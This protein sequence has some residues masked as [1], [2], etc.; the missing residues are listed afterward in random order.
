MADRPDI[1]ALLI[2]ALYGELTP[3]DE[4]RLTAHLESH[5]ADRTAL[6]NLTRTR[7]AIRESRIL[8]TL[9]EPP[10]S[11]SALLL[12]EAA[13]RAP[14]SSPTESWFQ[15]F[16]R[17][18]AAHPA[19]AAAATLV[20]VVGV[21]GLLYMRNSDPFSAPQA[22]RAAV[23]MSATANE[24]KAA[25]SAPSAAGS[26]ALPPA[27]DNSIVAAPEGVSDGKAPPSNKAYR[28]DV[29][30]ELATPT[31][32]AP[33][34]LAKGGIEVHRD[35]P[36][37]KDFD[38][39]VVARSRAGLSKESP[40]SGGAGGTGAVLGQAPAATA[41][42]PQPAT[43]MQAAASPEEPSS[44]P[45]GASGDLISARN[46]GADKPVTAPAPAA[47][48]KP[49]PATVTSAS[50]AE[51]E[52]EAKPSKL[53]KKRAPR[54][55]AKS[56]LPPSDEQVVLGWAQRQRDQVIAYVRANNCR[57]AAAAATEVYNRA[58]DYYASNIA[59]DRSIKPCA[60]YL[61]NERESVDRKRAAAKRTN[62]DE[63]AASKI[64]SAA[65]PAPSPSRK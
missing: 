29:A 42:A 26:A 44:P 41:A 5:P 43:P 32:A 19:M 46:L 55:E 64:P 17:A 36:M 4:A 9:L 8:V 6:D 50:D 61:T 13:R 48:P 57:A 49:A 40:S 22:E 54:D 23:P 38:D 18:F 31:K 60:T 2:G 39:S 24:E 1:D 30:D 16:V 59:A 51:P 63:P 58:P 53:A 27:A 35:D 21:A 52:A 12:Q 25:A 62:A 47:I 3:A 15:R 34:R 28:A 65:A 14:R 11:L 33:A 45:L 20:L 10:Q 56:E 37:P 7:A